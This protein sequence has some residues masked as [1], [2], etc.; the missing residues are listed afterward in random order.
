MDFPP[1]DFARIRTYPLRERDNKVQADSLAKVWQKGG[2]LAG[3]LQ[4]AEGPHLSAGPSS[5]PCLHGMVARGGCGLAQNA[6]LQQV[7]HRHFA[8]IFSGR[9]FEP[10]KWK[11]TFLEHAGFSSR[12]F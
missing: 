9:A 1:L 6:A 4:N 3:F 12:A 7:P 2:T 10:E 8:L 11:S 5:T